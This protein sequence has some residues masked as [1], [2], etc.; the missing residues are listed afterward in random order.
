MLQR[1]ARCPALERQIVMTTAAAG[2]RPNPIQGCMLVSRK[3]KGPVDLEVATGYFLFRSAWAFWK[4][5]ISS[6][7]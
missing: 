3:V 6:L 1:C 4:F 2:S 5:W 7:L